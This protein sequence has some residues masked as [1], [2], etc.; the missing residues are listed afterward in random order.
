V[1][2]RISTTTGTPEDACDVSNTGARV[3]FV[4]AQS[5]MPIQLAFP[6]STP[7]PPHIF[8]NYAPL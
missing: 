5:G 8:I 4:I 2:I 3:P 7:S 6:F 1:I